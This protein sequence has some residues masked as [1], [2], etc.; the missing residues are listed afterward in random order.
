[1][2]TLKSVA[3][4]GDRSENFPDGLPDHMRAVAATIDT[5][6]QNGIVKLVTKQ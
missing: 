6:V 4:E 1:V 5:Q 3:N 2:T